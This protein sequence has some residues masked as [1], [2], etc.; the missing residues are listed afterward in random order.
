MSHIIDT[1]S[2]E[3]NGSKPLMVNPFS[4][5]GTLASGRAAARRAMLQGEMPIAAVASVSRVSSIT[6]NCQAIIMGS[7]TYTFESTPTTKVNLLII[8]PT[9]C[10]TG[11]EDVFQP[12]TD[13]NGNLL[14]PLLRMNKAAKTLVLPVSKSDKH[15]DNLAAWAKKNKIFV[16][17]PDTMEF[18]G[19]QWL[20]VKWQGTGT[21]VFELHAPVAVTISVFGYIVS[22]DPDPKKPNA[23][24]KTPDGVG[25]SVRIHTVKKL[26]PPN[27]PLLASIFV[28][29]PTLTGQPVKSLAEMVRVDKEL[30]N[31]GKN[32][33]IDMV[34][35]VPVVVPS[36]CGIEDLENHVYELP[37]GSLATVAF[38]ATQKLAYKHV[39]K[40]GNELR[41]ADL[42]F[43]LK[44]WNADESRENH[45]IDLRLWEDALAIYGCNEMGAWGLGMAKALVLQTPTFFVG[46]CKHTES[47]DKFKANTRDDI[48]SIMTLEAKQPVADLPG[49]IANI[50][51]I[52]VSARFA[53][54]L[55][56]PQKRQAGQTQASY[57]PMLWIVPAET[58]KENMYNNTADPLMIVLNEYDPQQRRAVFEDHEAKFVFFAVMGNKL[59]GSRDLGFL[60]KLRKMQ[61]NAAYK[62]PLGEMLLWKDWNIDEPHKWRTAVYPGV[63]ADVETTIAADHPVL[64]E[65]FNTFSD[66]SAFYL[67]AISVERYNAALAPSARSIL[68]I[69]GKPSAAAAAVPALA[70][71]AAPTKRE[72]EA[73]SENAAAAEPS[74]E[75]DEE[76]ENGAG[77]RFSK[78]ARLE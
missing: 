63:T 55:A 15:A 2:K 62:G 53:Q 66:G 13:K 54:H 71:A 58:G 44:R 8:D 3:L 67:Y 49:S 21:P 12:K 37:A 4:S 36:L 9:Q 31:A 75:D 64:T 19:P 11:A 43:T 51:G 61:Q 24:I 60:E 7:H 52:P 70:A 10:Y 56:L 69:E 39:M 42:I 22:P 30:K 68:S 65:K 78:A 32:G 35:S 6:F 17:C 23:V 16:D 28:N 46:F 47:D 50:Y 59:M 48:N 18:K 27:S 14:P 72:R 38:Q 77:G 40:D 34:G 74:A 41:I 76:D 33:K 45:V 1:S 57:H 25:V 26:G 73:T 29:T 5:T 20:D